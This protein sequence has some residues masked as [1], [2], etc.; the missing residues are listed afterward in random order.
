MNTKQQIQ[1]I[2]K[3]NSNKFWVA[4]GAALHWKQEEFPCNDIDV[5]VM[6]SLTYGFVQNTLF[7]FP[8]YETKESQGFVTKFT[9][10]NLLP[11][12]LI[13]TAGTNIKEI[14]N[15]FDFT[16]CQVAIRGQLLTSYYTPEFLLD[17][18]NKT[19]RW[20][21]FNGFYGMMERISKYKNKGFVDDEY[22]WKCTL[23]SL[24]TP[25]ALNSSF[26][27]YDDEETHGGNAFSYDINNLF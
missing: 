27:E 14:L 24:L 7:M 3:I 21:K 12:Q 13:Y 8:E 6:D 15:G 11:V 17:V 23:E 10:K 1:R 5:Y 26:V 20:N 4:G 22:F 19:L 16:C 18:K 25:D 9:F 2:L